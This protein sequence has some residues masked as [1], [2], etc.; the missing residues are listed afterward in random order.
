MKLLAAAFVL[1][2]MLTGC[3][4]RLAGAPALGEPIRVVVVSNDARLVRSQAAL[5]QAVADSLQSRLGWQ[6]SPTGSAK[7]E[8][9]IAQERIASTGTDQRDVPARW[10][11]RMQGKVL[12]AARDGNAFG[13]YQGTGYSSGL[14]DEPEAIKAAAAEAALLISTWLES[15]VPRWKKPA[16]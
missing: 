13:D 16:P 14:G 5:Q 6:V 10:S 4:Y 1:A 12:I 8:L 7:L 2:A 3:G 11:I 9:T 15:E